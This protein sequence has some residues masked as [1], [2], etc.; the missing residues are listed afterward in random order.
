MKNFKTEGIV[1]KAMQ[2]FNVQLNGWNTAQTKEQRAASKLAMKQIS[3]NLKQNNPEAWAMFQS[4]MQP[5][6][7]K[8]EEKI[9][10]PT[11]KVTTPK[12][13]KPEVKPTEPIKPEATPTENNPKVGAGAVNSGGKTKIDMIE[14]GNDQK[15]LGQGQPQ[16][17]GT[18]KNIIVRK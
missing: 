6:V 13:L 1:N 10:K 18:E 14:K 2:D 3:D 8:V 11:E 9:K 4:K 7:A 16:Q 5:Q 15:N 17:V 12:E